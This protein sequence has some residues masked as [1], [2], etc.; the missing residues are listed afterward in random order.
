MK[1]IP[2][3]FS[4]RFSIFMSSST[5]KA[6]ML[7]DIS[8]QLARDAN[9][10]E[11]SKDFST[12]GNTLEK[13]IGQRI[14]WTLKN[15]QPPYHAFEG[16]VNDLTLEAIK[17]GVETGNMATGFLLAKESL[18]KSDGMFGSLIWGFLIPIAKILSILLGG[19]FLGNYIF[20]QLKG[21]TPVRRWPGISQF[22][23]G[24]TSFIAE[25]FMLI[26]MLILA[27]ILITTLI[28]KYVTGNTRRFFDSLPF[29]KQYRIMTAAITLTSMAMLIKADKP[30]LAT[31]QFLERK[32]KKYVRWHLG[33]MRQN[34]TR[35]KGT[36]SIGNMLDTGLIN[37][38]EITRLSRPMEITVI[39]DRLE[40]SAEEHSIMMQRQIARIKSVNQ[41]VFYVSLVGM[42]GLIFVSVIFMAL[43]MTS[44]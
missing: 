4:N 36:G 17:A 22:T 41:A 1:K 12:Y 3:T 35:V 31:V 40:E 33:Q 29:F 38:R 7:L 25:N 23:Y 21:L 2:M 16:V 13:I 44:I 28:I 5:D 26:V 19:G 14:A 42:I 24:F 11:I 6:T 8:R 20:G 15:G 39:A 34:I 37:T 43:S 10:D 27:A 9:M 30:I 32:A 18:E